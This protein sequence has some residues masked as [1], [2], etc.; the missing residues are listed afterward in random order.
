MLFAFRTLWHLIFPMFSNRTYPDYIIALA[1]EMSKVHLLFLFSLT[2]KWVTYHFI[3][4]KEKSTQE[5]QSP[6]NTPKTHS[7]TATGNKLPFST[8]SDQQATSKN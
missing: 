8:A 3:I 6:R 4:K 7:H 5:G 2:R 1:S